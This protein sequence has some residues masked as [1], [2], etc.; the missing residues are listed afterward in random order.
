MAIVGREDI[1]NGG[2]KQCLM[3]YEQDMVEEAYR[4]G[5]STDL[6]IGSDIRN[7]G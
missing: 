1:L 4:D 3:L 5:S 2:N 6:W 7:F